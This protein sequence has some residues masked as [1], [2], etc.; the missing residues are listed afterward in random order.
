MR[1]KITGLGYFSK[2]A[3][4]AESRTQ[5]EPDPAVVW[6]WLSIAESWRR[7]AE[8]TLVERAGIFC[9]TSPAAVERHSG[10]L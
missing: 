8:R 5:S 6:E 9:T 2:M 3:K 1:P 4:P 10:R 7:M